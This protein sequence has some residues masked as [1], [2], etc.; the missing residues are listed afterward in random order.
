MT[1]GTLGDCGMPFLSSM[2]GIFVRLAVVTY[3]ATRTQHGRVVDWRTIGPYIDQTA[4]LSQSANLV[5][6]GAAEERPGNVEFF[7]FGH[8]ANL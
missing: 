6:N 5:G 7:Q 3:T 4:G 2:L 1:G 8:P